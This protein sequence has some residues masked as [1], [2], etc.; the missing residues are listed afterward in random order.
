M[1]EAVGASTFGEDI[2]RS[3]IADRLNSAALRLTRRVRREDRALGETPARLSIIS[4]LVNRGPTTLA[5]LAELEQ[6]RPP[7]VTR[8]VQALERDGYVVRRT[9]RHDA[10][11]SL[12][13][14][15][16]KAWKLLEDIRERRLGALRSGLARLGPDELRTLEHA[17]VLIDRLATH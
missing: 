5:D 13:T 7:T 6:V 4:T 10:R 14:S 15:T 8:L 1:T 3:D 12:I 16:S 11:V 9:A 17:A 2:R